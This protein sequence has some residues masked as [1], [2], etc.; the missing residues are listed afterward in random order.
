MAELT[1]YQN[2][3]PLF[4]QYDR[5]QMMYYVDLWNYQQIKQHAKTILLSLKPRMIDG[6]PDPA[7]WSEL[8]EVHVMPKYTGPWPESQVE[9]FSQWIDQ[10]CKE[11][12]PPVKPVTPGP[13]AE[14]FLALSKVLTG[15]DD[16]ADKVLAQ[17]YINRLNNESA[18]AKNGQLD[19]L[20]TQFSSNPNLLDNNGHLTS[21]YQSYLTLI[22][23]ITV[24]W[25]NA[26]INGVQ[27]T[28]DNNQY[29]QGLV[30]RA[31]QAHPMGYADSNEQFYWQYQPEGSRYTGLQSVVPRALSEYKGSENE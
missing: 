25:Y 17:I 4:T 2:I 24:L 29:V 20:L 14:I 21:D 11:G 16:L 18:A 7:G 22:Q 1:F 13:Q 6:K 15:F 28:P 27:G 26:S 3:R 23:D 19:K 10:G 5:I 31:I 12:T 30:W 8:P 9:L